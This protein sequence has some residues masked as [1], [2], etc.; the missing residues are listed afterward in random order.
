M[1]QLIIILI[2][3]FVAV[4]GNA[5]IT[6]NNSPYLPYGENTTILNQT[7][8]GGTNDISGSGFT[9]PSEGKWRVVVT[10]TL[11]SNNGGINGS[12]FIFTNANAVVPKFKLGAYFSSGSWSDY[13][14][15]TSSVIIAT[16]GS[17][18]F[19]LKSYFPIGTG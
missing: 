7:L 17:E 5:Q 19:K 15:V 16:I 12:I 3:C 14:Q 18:S 10:A 6:P 1:K 9:L 4:R 2:F 13:K 8:L 11:A